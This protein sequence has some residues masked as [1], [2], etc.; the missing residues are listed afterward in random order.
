M[1]QPGSDREAKIERTVPQLHKLIT[2]VQTRHDRHT[3]YRPSR[4]RTHAA[5]TALINHLD[6][7]HVVERDSLRLLAHGLTAA[8]HDVLMLVD[9]VVDRVV[10][11]RG[12]STVIN[13]Y[14]LINIV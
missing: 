1:L 8:A 7:R 10:A 4:M 6:V 11:E 13:Y 5:A 9:L 12:I 2:G 14:Q 3:W